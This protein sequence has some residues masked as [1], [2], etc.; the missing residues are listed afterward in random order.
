MI[1]YQMSR[2]VHATDE[3]KDQDDFS[4]SLLVIGV[5]IV[6]ELL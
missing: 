3:T 6:S 4:N 5:H 1:V 2:E